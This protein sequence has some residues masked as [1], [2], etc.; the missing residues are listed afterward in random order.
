M[1]RMFMLCKW[2]FARTVKTSTYN[3]LHNTINKTWRWRHVSRHPLI[4]AKNHN[5]QNCVACRRVQS[6]STWKSHPETVQQLPSSRWSPPKGWSTRNEE[7]NRKKSQLK[8]SIVYF[9]VNTTTVK[10]YAQQRTRRRSKS[11]D[12]TDRFIMAEELGKWY[13]IS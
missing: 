13:E 10:Y 3:A 8:P 1:R 4:G 12:E 11:V 6:C 9:Y 2:D 5:L 7:N